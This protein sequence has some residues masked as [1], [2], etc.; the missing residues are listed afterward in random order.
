MCIK[1]FAV[2]DKSGIWQKYFALKKRG[3]K[4]NQWFGL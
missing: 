3:E 2:I 4:N 1:N